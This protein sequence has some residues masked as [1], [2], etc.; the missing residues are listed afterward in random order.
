MELLFGNGYLWK[1]IDDTKSCF[2]WMEVHDLIF[3][4]CV[5]TANS[6]R[7]QPTTSQFFHP[8]TPQTLVLVA[9]AI[10]YTLSEY[11]TGMK[12][13]VMFCQDKYQGKFCPSMVI[14]CITAEAITLLN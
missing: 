10:H 3:H 12:V 11:G 8:L 5:F 13:P 7:R 14:N 6:L 4:Q 1:V 2:M 9:A